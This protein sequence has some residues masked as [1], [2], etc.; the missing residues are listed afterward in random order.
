M[1]A[2]V[3]A[4]AVHL[5]SAEHRWRHRAPSRSTPG[6]VQCTSRHQTTQPDTPATR[7]VPTFSFVASDS[8]YLIHHPTTAVA[9]RTFCRPPSTVQRCPPLAAPVTKRYTNSHAHHTVGSNHS[10]C[11]PVTLPW[12]PSLPRS[13][14]S[15]SSTL[16]TTFF[17][18]R[19][20]SLFLSHDPKENPSRR[21]LFSK[22][23]IEPLPTLLSLKILY[24]AFP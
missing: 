13:S 9:A 11:L 6:T 21:Q 23:K 15:S 20:F 2:D 12:W 17:S 19:L 4:V 18:F 24:F 10:A 14:S 3:F 5:A 7:R 22:D 1:L 8:G 16:S